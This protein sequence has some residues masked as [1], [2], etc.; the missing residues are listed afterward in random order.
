GVNSVESELAQ[1]D[2]ATTSSRS[3]TMVP[4]TDTDDPNDDNGTSDI[5]EATDT[6]KEIIEGDEKAK[7]LSI[8]SMVLTCHL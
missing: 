5:T 8:L 1:H 4:V 2:D 7:L 3:T 6:T